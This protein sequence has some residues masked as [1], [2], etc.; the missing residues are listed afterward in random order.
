MVMGLSPFMVIFGAIYHWFPKMS[1]RMLND[2]LGKMHFWLTFLGAYCVFLPM[3]Y[4]GLLGVPRRY[5]FYGETGFI[6]DS[7]TV[8][9]RGNYDC[10]LC[11]IG[12]AA[13]LLRQSVLEPALRQK[14]ERQ[15]LARDITRVADTR[16]AGKTRQ[17]G[18]RAAGRASLGIRLQCPGS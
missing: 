5:F 14:G 17:L 11:R 12:R 2:T 16:H 15:P 9:Q 13:H 6:P 1:G 3:H 7:A 18:P 4:I 10:R 8:R